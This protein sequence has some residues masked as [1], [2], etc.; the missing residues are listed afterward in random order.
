MQG[1]YI[2]KG[3]DRF[4]GGIV[5]D[6]AVASR[7]EQKQPSQNPSA[8]PSHFCLPLEFV[9]IPHSSG[10]GIAPGVPCDIDRSQ[11]PLFRAP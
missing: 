5:V 1:V 6:V 7:V 8:S 3:C 4:P 9:G 2:D 11:F 10:E